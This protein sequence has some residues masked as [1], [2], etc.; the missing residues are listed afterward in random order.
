MTRIFKYLASAPYSGY[1]EYLRKKDANFAKNKKIN[2]STESYTNHPASSGICGFVGYSA[3]EPYSLVDGNH[4]NGFF[5]YESDQPNRSIT[6]DLKREK[7][8][9]TSYTFMTSCAYPLNWYML[10]SN[11][12]SKWTILH[13]GS[14]QKGLSANPTTKHYE[15]TV[16]KNAY[17]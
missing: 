1:F 13:T 5:H 14:S 11:D 3:G 15:C 12:L 17:R 10:G 7:F 6:F 16:Y 9:L 2:I 8:I 4:K